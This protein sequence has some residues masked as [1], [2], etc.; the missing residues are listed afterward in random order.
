[1]KRMFS[2]RAL[3]MLVVLGVVT[4]SGFLLRGNAGLGQVQRMPMGPEQAPSDDAPKE[5]E[6]VKSPAAPRSDPARES[7]D[8][9]RQLLE[10]VGVLTAAHCYQTYVNIGL[11]ADGKDKGV[12]TGKDAQKVLDSVVSLLDSVDGKL[13]ALGKLDLDEQ[14][15]ASLDRLRVLSDLLRQQGKDLTEFWYSG[16]DQDASRYES[17]RKDSWAA[18]SKLMGISR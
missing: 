15:R 1:M 6:A 9:R 10:T 16:T 4:A 8:E 2:K 18:I 3:V 7:A 11:I 12:Y 5:S 13:S 17:A 14:D